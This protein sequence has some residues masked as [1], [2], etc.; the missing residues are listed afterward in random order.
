M[1]ANCFDCDKLTN[2]YRLVVWDFGF[3]GRRQRFESSWG[4]QK[5][6]WIDGIGVL[7]NGISSVALTMKMSAQGVNGMSIAVK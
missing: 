5:D 6:S 4:R 7:N 1:F 3:S 2:P